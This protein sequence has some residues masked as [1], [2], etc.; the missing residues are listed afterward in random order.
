MRCS[1]TGCLRKPQTKFSG[2]VL[3]TMCTGTGRRAQAGCTAFGRS[4]TWPTLCG[5]QG[6]ASSSRHIFIVPRVW[7]G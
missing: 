5:S 1:L 6:E 7:Q 4:K 2:L 3:F